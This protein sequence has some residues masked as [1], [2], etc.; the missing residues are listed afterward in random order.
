MQVNLPRKDLQKNSP[1]LCPKALELRTQQFPLRQETLGMGFVPMHLQL[2][3]L[4]GP[5]KTRI[6][7]HMFLEISKT[8]QHTR[9]YYG[10]GYNGKAWPLMKQQLSWHEKSSP[11]TP[12]T[13]K[14]H[15]GGGERNVGEMRLFLHSLNKLHQ[16]LISE[17]G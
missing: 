11:L 15:F 4:K 8:P 10:H 7:I 17:A 6:N 16:I 12:Q 1:Q 9:L 14:D 13:F 5:P 3:C 2:C